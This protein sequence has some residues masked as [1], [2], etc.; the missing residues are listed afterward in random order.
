MK[1]SVLFL[2]VLCLSL[3]GCQNK[4]EGKE[5]EVKDISEY[6]PNDKSEDKVAYAEFGETAPDI[7]LVKFDETEASLSDYLGKPTIMV[8]WATWCGY[9]KIELPALEMLKENYGDKINIIAVNCGDTAEDAKEFFEDKGYSFEAAMASFEDSLL[10]GADSIPVTVI[11]DKDGVIK[12]FE[13]G[14]A[15]AETMFRDYFSP[16][17]DELLEE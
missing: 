15:D 3:S 13:K 1:K 14:S 5:I 17:F 2:A 4:L 9:C 16:V 8:F 12:F 7:K 10:Y 6:D 11:M